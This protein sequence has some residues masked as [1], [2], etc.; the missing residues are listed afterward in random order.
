M[1]LKDDDPISKIKPYEEPRFDFLY[2]EIVTDAEWEEARGPE[3]IGPDADIMEVK[4]WPR[5]PSRKGKQIPVSDPLP[6]DTP[7]MY[8]TEADRAD[9]RGTPG[10]KRQGE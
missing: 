10:R 2:E 5:M 1:D 4:E 9:Y 8:L 7:V 3:K 6:P